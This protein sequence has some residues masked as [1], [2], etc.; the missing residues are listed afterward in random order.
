MTD[1]IEEIKCSRILANEITKLLLKDDHN[2]PE[3]LVT[4]YTNLLNVYA[5]EIDN[6]VP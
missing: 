2:L 6:N 3:S 4:A 1:Y 5:K